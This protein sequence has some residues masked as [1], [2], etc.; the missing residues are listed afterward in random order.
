MV[1]LA[2]SPVTAA[3]VADALRLPQRFDHRMQVLM[4]LNNEGKLSPEERAELEMLVELSEEMCLIRAAAL[5][6]MERRTR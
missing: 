2:E 1:R 6:G 3:E 4:D 5:A